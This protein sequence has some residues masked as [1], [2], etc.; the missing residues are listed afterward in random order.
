MSPRRWARGA[1]FQRRPGRF[2]LGR[3]RPRSRL[4]VFRSC[5]RNNFRWS[6]STAP[7]RRGWL[8]WFERATGRFGR[9]SHASRRQLVARNVERRGGRFSPLPM[10]T[11]PSQRHAADDEE[12]QWHR[13]RPAPALGLRAP[14]RLHRCAPTDSSCWAGS[15]GS[16]RTSLPS[17]S[18]SALSMARARRSRLC[19]AH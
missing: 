11:H 15:P 4:S 2:R 3:S 6:C 18:A 14:R 9:P 1:G 7:S 12:S 16:V 5:C 8:R 19:L 13:R 17:A 10:K